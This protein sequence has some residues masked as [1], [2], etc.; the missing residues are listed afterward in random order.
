MVLLL[1]CDLFAS[2]VLHTHATW[3]SPEHAV[4]TDTDEKKLLN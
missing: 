4:E 1:R 3:Y 2:R